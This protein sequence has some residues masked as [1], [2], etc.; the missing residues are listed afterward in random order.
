MNSERSI[1]TISLSE[2]ES[3]VTTETWKSGNDEGQ[4]RMIFKDVHWHFPN[5]TI[6]QLF[7]KNNCPHLNLVRAAVFA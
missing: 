3:L 5:F 1:G 4:F 7:T 2:M 6:N